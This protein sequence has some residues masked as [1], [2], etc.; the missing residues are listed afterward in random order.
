MAAGTIRAGDPDRV[1][2]QLWAA[3]HG[4][5]MLELAGLNLASSHPVEEVFRPLLTN[6]LEGLSTQPDR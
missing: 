1:A 3:M 6:L 5:V 2:Q 4:Y